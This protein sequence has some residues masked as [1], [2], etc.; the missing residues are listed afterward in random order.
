MAALVEEVETLIDRREG[1]TELAA[2]GRRLARL[3]LEHQYR[4]AVEWNGFDGYRSRL[5]RR[6]IEQLDAA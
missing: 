1:D 4:R 3:H 6:Q 2:I 5:L